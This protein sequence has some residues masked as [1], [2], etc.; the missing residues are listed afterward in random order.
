M[1]NMVYSTDQDQIGEWSPLLM[2][3]RNPSEKVAATRVA[4]GSDCNFG[5]MTKKLMNAFEANG[6]I[7]RFN[8]E[9]MGIAREGDR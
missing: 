8:S 4:K 1:E 3:G 9:V 5:V 2:K 6:G 7:T